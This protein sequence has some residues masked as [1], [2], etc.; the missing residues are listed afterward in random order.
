[1][2]PPC[3]RAPKRPTDAV[4]DIEGLGVFYMGRKVD[5]A[6]HAASQEPLLLAAKR[7]TTH[8][9][10]VGMTGSGKTGL[11]VSLIEEAALDG[12]PAIVIDP[13]GDL[14]NV[15][16]SFPELAA[17]DF[18]PW[19][20]AEAAAR[21]RLT[22]EQLAERTAKQWSEGLAAS[23]QSP[24]RIRRLHEAVEMTVYTPGS[25][26]GRPLAMLESLEPPPEHVLADAEAKRERIESLVS[27]IL[28]LV[29]IDA[30][31]G[32]SREHVLLS[33][34]IDVLWKSGQ[35]VDF[36]TLVRSIPAPPI[37][38]VG[39]LDLENFY[40]A[41][42]RFQLASRLNTVAAAPGFDA[43][44]DGEPL[45]VGR[46][47]WTPS[48]KPRV[49]VVSIA[50]LSDAQRMAFVTLL[51][52]QTLSWMRTQGGTTS[53]KALFL[54]DEVFG[55]LPPTAN[56]PSK[57]PLL[58]LLKQARAYGLGIV[59][60]TQNPVDL[61]Y[62]GLANAG[63][64]FLG[65]LQTARDKARVLDGLEGAAST[66]GAAFDRGAV[67]RLLSGLGQRMFLM[68]SVHE[69]GETVFQTR[70]TMAYLRGPLLREE[71]RRLTRGDASAAIETSPD[72]RLP[73][74]SE[75]R[76]GPRPILPPGVREVFL[77]PEHQMP[78]DADILYRP[79][80]LGRARVRYTHSTARVD[81]DREIVCLAPASDSLGE[82]AW[83]AGRQLD[84]PPEIEPAPRPGSFAP[85]P[86][87]LA[88]PRGYTT[89]ATSLKNHLGRSS[90]LT[91]WR[92][93][94]I[95]AVSRPDES[96]ADFRVRIAQRVKEWRDAEMER[97]RDRHAA[98]LATL[99]DRIERARQKVER[100]KAEAKNQSLQTYVSIGSAVLGALLGRKLASSTTIGKAATSMRSASRAARQQA[101][102]A[103][104][105][106]SL[107]TLEERRLAL[108]EEIATELDRLRLET[109]PDRIEVERIEV[110]ARKTGTSIEDVV[111]A[112][113]PS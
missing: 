47:L 24:E 97:V 22:A 71:I 102:V 6:T 23:G 83:E 70:W 54:M 113:V 78:L 68:H 45:D 42:D 72:R 109:T 63:L 56:P 103:H 36:G 81:V 48:G 29:G 75:P 94:S 66:A 82:S 99:T 67:E 73:H 44:L 34:I 3:G 16:L 91:V 96:E 19:I 43:W 89:L 55:Y 49:S 104:A 40:P 80:I 108:E 74:G 101:D 60:A 65:R 4:A 18:L 105:E 20:E 57:T 106:E 10:C 17:S 14:A 85:L 30:E 1:M 77:A 25:R 46:L 5:P 13:K 50:H 52:G 11:L 15:L 61:D 62:K 90:T 76:G 12:I 87:S 32:T 7:L 21:E 98:K 93:P 92:A 112:W 2:P 53:L 37:E 27:G 88:G 39:F 41:G 84:E 31:P 35:K 64:W 110:P 79:S 8:A 69:D 100:E 95:D 26:T 28:A 107:L 58:T 59:L 9:V 33:T 111:L 38:R 51:A 86:G